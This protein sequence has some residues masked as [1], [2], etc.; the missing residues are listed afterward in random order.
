MWPIWTNFTT[1]S[2][3]PSGWGLGYP[4][5]HIYW[6]KQLLWTNWLR[7]LL[8]IKLKVIRLFLSTKKDLRFSHY[9][10][11]KDSFGPEVPKSHWVKILKHPIEYKLSKTVF[12]AFQLQRKSCGEVAHWLLRM[13][14][15]HTKYMVCIDVYFGASFNKVCSIENQ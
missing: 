10:T 2:P 4:Q 13:H 14:V 5:R 8:E 9:V 15:L 12:W 1:Y 11:Q 3:F 6:S 7:R